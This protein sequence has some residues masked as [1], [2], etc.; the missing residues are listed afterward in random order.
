MNQ[1]HLNNQF[2]WLITGAAGF[3]GSHL[4]EELLNLNQNVIG[5]DNF[6][7]GFQHNLDHIRRSVGPDKW[8]NLTFH[9]GDTR[10][11][12]L[13]SEVCSNVDYILHQAALGSVPRSIK[14]PQSSHQSNIDGFFNIIDSAKNTK[15]KKIVFASSS[16]VY[17][18]N[19]TLP[20]VENEIG[21][22]LS[23]YALTK[24]INELY[25]DVF[26]RT[27]HLPIVGLRYF[28]VFGPR[29]NINGPYAAVIPKWIHCILEEKSIDIYGDGEN[30]RDFTYIKNVVH[31]NILTA[32]SDNTEMH[33]DVFNVAL[34]QKTT[35]NELYQ[36]I[37]KNLASLD[38]SIKVKNA[39]YTSP[40]EGDIK[41]SQANI[42]KFTKA[43]HFE[44]QV[45]INDG[46]QETIKWFINN[47][48][49]SH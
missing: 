16:S 42:S 25:A 13:C 41:N 23:P 21:K 17:G 22:C 46:L 14:D 34:G 40:R 36:N 31:A 29:Q 6:S 28:N 3:I 20:K 32:L 15:I 47:A 12:K 30:G 24:K 45:T 19:E 27:Y 44:A 18:D 2:T 7:T 5:L 10:N 38:H 37:S 8:K 49:N 43:T 26:Y 9:E 11:L 33:G 1:Y 35:L 39:N 4:V 48:Q